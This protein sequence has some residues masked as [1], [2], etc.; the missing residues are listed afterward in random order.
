MTLGPVVYPLHAFAVVLIVGTVIVL[1]A[2]RWIAA[3]IYGAGA[4]W[5]ILSQITVFLFGTPGDQLTLGIQLVLWL[6][7]GTI[8]LART[9]FE[10]ADADHT[11]SGMDPRWALTAVAFLGELLDDPAPP[12]RPGHRPDPKS[13]TDHEQ[14][15]PPATEDA[16]DQSDEEYTGPLDVMANDARWLVR[17]L[18]RRSTRDTDED[19]R[20]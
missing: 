12:Q 3:S 7:P 14:P 17:V 8:L 6:L 9:V 16:P 19:E 10:P 4:C 13:E 18:T 11:T 20:P 15:P 2:P 1:L 5:L